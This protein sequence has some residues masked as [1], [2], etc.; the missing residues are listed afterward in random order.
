MSGHQSK[1]EE[2]DP[3]YQRIYEGLQDFFERHE[4]V[5]TRSRPVQPYDL[6]DVLRVCQE[7]VRLHREAGREVVFNITGGTKLMA[8]AAYLCAQREQV[9]VIYVESRD[10]LLITLPPPG[11]SIDDAS[12]NEFASE[13]R[14]F[15]EERF[16]VVDVPSYVKFYG[17]EVNTSVTIDDMD[18]IDRIKSKSLAVSYSLIRVFLK[19]LR[20]EVAKRYKARNSGEILS[21]PI[22]IQC[23]KVT[24][25]QRI[26]LKNLSDKGVLY[27]DE[28]RL[29]ISCDQDQHRFLKGKWI[30]VFVLVSLSESGLFHDV[31]G[32]ITL[33]GVDGEWDIMLTANATLAILECKSD[34]NLTEQFGRIRSVQNDLGGFYAK[35]FFVRSRDGSERTEM[36]LAELYRI[37]QV[38]N[39]DDMPRIVEK[40]AEVMGLQRK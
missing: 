20:E 11:D 36:A 31:R 7:T 28:D 8:M 29:C 21:W 4:R 24:K 37:T 34:A 10:R 6:A 16:R 3:K 1:Y 23:Q 13:R 17:R 18:P 22:E 14:S 40:V 25:K 35:S 9:E 2:Y 39:I 19:Q 32:E 12:A 27:W 33:V 30:E 5:V 38:L 15:L 26:E